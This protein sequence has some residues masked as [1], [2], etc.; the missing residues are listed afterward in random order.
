[1]LQVIRNAVLGKFPPDT[2]AR[3]A[4]SS[5]FWAPS[6]DHKSWNHPM[7]AKPVIVAFAD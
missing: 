3:P 4:G 5:S 7:E 2:V 1:M 6:L